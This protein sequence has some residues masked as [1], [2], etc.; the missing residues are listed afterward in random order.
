MNNEI[1]KAQASEVAIQG[2]VGEAVLLDYLKTLGTNLPDNMAKQFLHI[3]KAFNLNPFKREIYAIPYKKWNSNTRTEE[4]TLSIVTG[5]E[6]YIRR[7]ER[8]NQLSG[9]S[10]TT[11]GSIEKKTIAGYQNKPKDVWRGDLKAI[12]TIHR[13]DFQHPFIW[14]VEWDEYTQDNQMWGEKPKTMLKKVAITQAFRMCFSEQTDGLPYTS[15]ELPSKMGIEATV[16]QPE[17]AFPEPTAPA[18][19]PA[20]EPAKRTSRKA[21]PVAVEAEIVPPAQPEPAAPPAEE[22]PPHTEADAPPLEMSNEPQLSTEDQLREVLIPCR[23][24]TELTKAI[25]EFQTATGIMT[26]NVPALKDICVTKKLMIERNEHEGTI[27]P[28]GMMWN[29]KLVSCF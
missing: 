4:L 2:Q 24:T 14:E 8:S 23:S 11:T 7:A 1:Q 29:D 25:R 5:Y 3:A 18:Q 17:P 21:A 28:D 6:T 27:G 13:K 22:P 26:S 16:G 20:A 10:V 19:Q 12:V 9:W 15:D